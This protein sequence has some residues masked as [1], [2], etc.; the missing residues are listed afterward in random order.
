M[1]SEDYLLENR[2]M[3]NFRPKSKNQVDG[4]KNLGPMPK[5]GGSKKI[6]D[7]REKRSEG[8]AD[9]VTCGF[10]SWGIVG[11]AEGSG[12]IGVTS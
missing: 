12:E 2:K 7:I 1:E 8:K 9:G 11:I 5:A 10:G 3:S 4:A 6:G